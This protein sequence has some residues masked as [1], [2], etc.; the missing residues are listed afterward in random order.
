MCV[1]FIF[2]Y[3]LLFLNTQKLLLLIKYF[4]ENVNKMLQWEKERNI[5]TQ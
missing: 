3:V 5:Y 2:F 4:R 1:Y